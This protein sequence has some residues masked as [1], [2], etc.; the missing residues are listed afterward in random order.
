MPRLP[1]R[2]EA[3][4]IEEH[5]LA[6]V[7]SDIGTAE[8]SKAFFIDLATIIK[9]DLSLRS[10]I[11]IAEAML[12]YAAD[13]R[14]L[15][16]AET[17]VEARRRAYGLRR[18][19]SDLQ[20]TLAKFEFQWANAAEAVRLKGRLEAARECGAIFENARQHHKQFESLYGDLSGMPDKR[21][22]EMGDAMW[23]AMSKIAPPFRF[24]DCRGAIADLDAVLES[25]SNVTGSQKGRAPPSKALTDMIARLM[26]T[27]EDATGRSASG[28][29]AG[30]QSFAKRIRRA[31]PPS[32]HNADTAGAALSRRIRRMSANR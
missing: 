27:F 9:A 18:E 16:G 2:E 1:T 30:F 4:A 20:K 29:R 24:A 7:W 6:D 8:D 22:C 12:G 31:L 13:I 19:T 15:R 3:K 21:L 17:L 5:R 14:F 32:I 26:E 23:Q 25:W 28:P 11:G 10:R